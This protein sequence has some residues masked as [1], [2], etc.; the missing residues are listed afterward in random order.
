M[1]Q[2]TAKEKLL[3]YC[4]NNQKDYIYIT[5]QREFDCLVSLV[6][7]GDVTTFEDLYMYGME[8]SFLKNK[9]N[10]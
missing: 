9:L 3:E 8:E 7:D 4:Y 1:A 6:E 2:Q 10:K 5:S